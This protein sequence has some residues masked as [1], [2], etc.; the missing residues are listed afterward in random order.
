MKKISFNYKGKKF[1]IAA[2][3]CRFFSPG[4]IFRTRNTEP[5]LFEFK[6][7]T[8]FKISSLFVFF[9]FIAVWL[10]GKDKVIEIKKIRPFTFSAGIKEPFYKIVEIP[11]SDNYKKF[12]F[13][14]GD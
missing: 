10:D 11:L 4:L 1:N 8:R 5:C 13:L 7:P 9:P 2:K 6:E 12:K 14:V 3:P